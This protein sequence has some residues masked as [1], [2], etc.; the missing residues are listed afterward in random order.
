M[1][2][3]SAIASAF[4]V[5]T[6]LAVE[7]AVQLDFSVSRPSTSGLTKRDNSTVVFNLMN[8]NIIYNVK[9]GLGSQNLPQIVQ[10]DTGSSDLWVMADNVQC[11]LGTRLV[12][13]STCLATGSYSTSSSLSFQQDNDIGPFGIMYADGTSTQGVFAKDKLTI[14]NITIP[15]MIFGVANVTSSSNPVFGIGLPQIESSYFDSGTTY[16][17]FPM[18][19]KL[20]GLVKKNAYSLFLNSTNATSGSVL[21]GAVDHKKYTGALQTVPMVLGLNET[22]PSRFSIV[23]DDLSINGNGASI[24]VSNQPI[25][26]ILDSGAQSTYMPSQFVDAMAKMLGMTNIKGAPQ[27]KAISC[28]YLNLNMTFTFDFSGAKIEVPL[29]NFVY[30]ATDKSCIFGIRPSSTGGSILGDNFL[31]GAYVVYDLQDLEISLAKASFNAGSNIEV[32]SSAIPSA[33][34]AALYSQTSYQTLFTSIAQ[35]TGFDPQGQTRKSGAPAS[36]MSEAFYLAL[37][38]VGGLFFL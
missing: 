19:L 15:D 8:Q 35:P 33:V 10:V 25:S 32:I 27:V 4:I 1:L 5:G 38:F 29:S 12:A 21:F 6:S 31:S 7:N 3:L 17:N 9:I 16:E 24:Q 18:R 30:P 26:V 37:A 14:G 28:L 2:H 20:M 13:A 11:Y 23:L 22:S 34:R 36:G